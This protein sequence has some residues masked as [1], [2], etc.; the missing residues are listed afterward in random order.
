MKAAAL[1]VLVGCASGGGDA[2]YPADAPHLRVLTYNMN[3]GVAGDRAGADAIRSAS[4]DI[5]LLQETNDEWQAALTGMFPHER[6]QGPKTEWVAGGM[7]VMS[8][9]PIASVDELTSDAGPFFAWR[10][11]VDAP[12]GPIQLVNVHLHPPM[13]TQSGSWVV[14]YF[15]TRAVREQE[16]K[17]HIAN[18][19][20]SLPTIVAGDFNEEDEG[21]AIALF[22][23]KGLASALPRFRPDADT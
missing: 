19:D 4:P 3:F 12:G 1:V 7:G 11:V 20:W 5:A 17:D 6:F 23:T 14:G 22:R 2:A 16:A 9:W 10:V 21:R 18:I 13:D 8:K 15:S